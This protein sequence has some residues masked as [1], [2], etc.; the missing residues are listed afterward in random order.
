M[1][2]RHLKTFIAV[3]STLNVTRAAE[4][5]HLAQSSV[6]GQIQALEDELGTP[7][8]DRSRR[9]LRLTPAGQRLQDYAAKLLALADEARAAVAGAGAAVAGR[10]LI[11][12]LETLCAMR[13]PALLVAYR[14]RCP[15][16]EVTLRAANSSELR[17]AVKSGA[18]DVCFVFGDVVDDPELEHEAV[19]HEA[20]A[21]IAPPGHP[22]AARRSLASADLAG[23]PFLVTETGC[24]YRRMFDR[25]FA[26]LGGAAPRIAGEYGSIAA[27]RTL[28]ESG[29]GCALL[30]R[31]V[32]A[33][34]MADGRLA[35][36]PWPG[37]EPR[38]AV[39]MLWRRRRTQAPALREFIELARAH[40]GAATPADV[41]PRRAARSR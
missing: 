22:L 26:P 21:V 3:A 37:E 7:L 1:Q 11:G 29:E 6:S 23:A 10:L 39:T 32:V 8:F 9:G 5:V 18:A 31:F 17:G 13:L 4:R 24:V 30:P 14:Q 19:A 34:A 2:L 38:V 41:R 28:V 27:I 40:F 36:L 20:L 33:D 25:A 35:A 15:A 16:V 12:G